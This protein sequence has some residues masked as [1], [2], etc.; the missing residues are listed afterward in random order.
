[1]KKKKQIILLLVLAAIAV[2]FIAEWDAIVEGF[3][4]GMESVPPAR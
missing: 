1:M 2:F 4:N 3:R